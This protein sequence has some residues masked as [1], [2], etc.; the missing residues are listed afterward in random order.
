MSTEPIVSVVIIFLNEEAFLAEAIESVL[1]QTFSAWE[2]L[3]VDDGSTDGSTEIARAYTVQRP[4]QIRYLEHPGHANRGMSASRNLGIGAAKGD[5]IALLDGDDVWLPHKLADQ[6]A[7]LEAH[8]EAGLLYGQ[9]LYWYSWTQNPSDQRRDFLPASGVPGQTLMQPPR[10]LSLFLRGKTAV[11]CPSS[12][13][14][15]R[16][17]MEATGGFVETFVGPYTVYEDQAFYSK[18]CLQTPILVCDTCWD[19]YRQHPHASTAISKKT[20]Q[21]TA[22][23]Q[24]FLRWLQE[25]LRQQGVTD[26]D[27]CQAV[28]HEQWEIHQ[29]PWIP[30]I[31]P[32]PRLIRWAKKWLLHLNSISD[33]RHRGEV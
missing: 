15:R 12:I 11:P 19:H 17:A 28:R 5:Y 1:A 33:G 2:L 3:L 26:T 14:V 7:M 16:S 8:D 10:L 25:Y 6:V 27:L 9:S 29:P 18:V 13:L 30:S 23:R 21:E 22:A 20:G 31:G 32:L 24:F 4:E